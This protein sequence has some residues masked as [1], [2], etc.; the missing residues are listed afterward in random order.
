VTDEF[1]Y[2]ESYFYLEIGQ[3][4]HG[5]ALLSGV[6]RENPYQRLFEVRVLLSDGR[7]RQA[8]DI[9][10]TLRADPDDEWYPS[11]QWMQATCLIAQSDYEPALR[12]LSELH[13]RCREAGDLSLLGLV[14]AQLGQVHLRRHQEDEALTMFESALEIH[15]HMRSLLGEASCWQGVAIVHSRKGDFAQAKEIFSRTLGICR[16]GGLRR[17]EAGA[18]ANLGRT[19]HR[20]GDLEGAAAELEQSIAMFRSLGSRE[21][22]GASLWNLARVRYEQGHREVGRAL[23]Q[24]VLDEH[25]ESTPSNMVEGAREALQTW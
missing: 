19:Q 2:F 5:A 18:H 9:L 25:S 4:E 21:A 6:G 13:T 10:A 7:V 22:I 24:E 17:L 23:A 11:R 15:Q 20:L 8:F 14:L 12:C 3:P 16:R 1:L